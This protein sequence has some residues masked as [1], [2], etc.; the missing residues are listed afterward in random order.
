MGRLEQLAETALNLDAL[1][2]RSLVQDWLREN[3]QIAD[4]ASPTS[5]DSDVIAT[6]AALVELLALRA[7]QVPPA[8]TAMVGSVRQPIFLL[9]AA[10]T[11]RRLRQECE[12]ES[13]LPLRRRGL[14]AP[15]DF[16][17][18]A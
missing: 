17:S 2:L 18:F 8:W 6:A 14:Y 12:N 11:M 10:R 15:A 13:P 3:P 7:Q 16:L 1:R 4:C 5:N 9:K